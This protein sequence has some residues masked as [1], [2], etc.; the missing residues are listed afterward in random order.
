MTIPAIFQS[1]KFQLALLGA[2]SSLPGVIFAVTDKGTTR[3]QKQ[4]TVQH[5]TDV[6][7]GII[8]LAV[9]GTA[10]E[11]FSKNWNPVGGNASPQPAPQVNVGSDVHNEPPKAPDVPQSPA[12]P[13]GIAPPRNVKLADGSTGVFVLMT[14]PVPKTPA[15]SPLRAAHEE[16]VLP[17]SDEKKD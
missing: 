14:P 15:I 12:I 5:Y 6:V 9:A 17:A 16:V 13:T 11:D 4:E 10:A 3:Q 2:I 7:V 1:R 8:A